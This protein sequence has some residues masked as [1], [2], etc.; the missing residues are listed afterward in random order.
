MEKYTKIIDQLALCFNDLEH[1][2]E[3]ELS[4]KVKEVIN[5]L[6]IKKWQEENMRQQN[7]ADELI[8]TLIGKTLDEARNLTNEKELAHRVR[9]I[10][11]KGCI[12]TCD[13]KPARLN[14]H[15]EN[16]IVTRITLG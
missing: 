9:S 4:N 11:G 10:D 8:P 13:F 5:E 15:I 6:E 14:Y 3:T 16:N 7:V 1:L 2:D 12:G